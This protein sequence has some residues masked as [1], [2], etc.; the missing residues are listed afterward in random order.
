RRHAAG[1]L[2]GGAERA[3][4]FADQGG[5]GL[6]RL[7]RRE[8][9]VVGSDDRQVG[10]GAAAQ[11]RLVGRAAG[12]EGVGEVAAAQA[13][14]VGPGLV[15]GIDAGQVGRARGA[16]AAADAFG[17]VVQ[18]GMQAHWTSGDWAYRWCR[19]RAVTGTRR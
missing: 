5:V 18:Y 6:V 16:A 7:V 15:H 1:D 13:R 17:D 14:A 9:V 8:H 11:A 10:R 19:G 3:G 2:G 12:G 4:V